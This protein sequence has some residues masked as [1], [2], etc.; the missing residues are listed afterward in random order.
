[1]D[2]Q[3]D[4]ANKDHWGTRGQG[5]LGRQEKTAE[6]TNDLDVGVPPSPVSAVPHD[7]QSHRPN[8]AV[9]RCVQDRDG[10]RLQQSKPVDARLTRGTAPGPVPRDG[11]RRESSDKAL[12][13]LR[14]SSAGDG[15]GPRA[16]FAHVVSFRDLLAGGVFQAGTVRP[17]Q[18]RVEA[19]QRR[20]DAKGT[21]L[22]SDRR[23]DT[24]MLSMLSMLSVSFT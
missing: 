22:P 7:R 1:M 8:L 18:P 20:N 10:D 23:I 2:R 17:R 5:R 15:Q 11:Q 4:P 16:A 19:G 13:S 21:M 24:T 3:T 12:P 9:E 14:A 6:Q